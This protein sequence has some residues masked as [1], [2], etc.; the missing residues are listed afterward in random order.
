MCWPSS[1]Q[2]FGCK[3][4]KNVS[5]HQLEWNEH[6]FLLPSSPND[7]NPRIAH[8]PYATFPASLNGLFRGQMV[9]LIQTLSYKSLV[10]PWGEVVG[11][12]VVVSLLYSHEISAT[13]ALETW[14][15]SLQTENK[16]WWQKSGAENLK[17]GELWENNPFPFEMLPFFSGDIRSY[18][19]RV[20]LILAA[21]GCISQL[22][23]IGSLN[24]QEYHMPPENRP[25]FSHMNLSLIPHVYQ[26]SADRNLALWLPVVIGFEVPPAPFIP[27]FQSIRS[28][29]QSHVT[30]H[31]PTLHLLQRLQWVQGEQHRRVVA[32]CKTQRIVASDLLS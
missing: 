24:H 29:I 27:P 10:S 4:R 26:R 8:P 1:K 7:G 3:I 31:G 32:R 5:N 20:A 18:S 17:H 12:G 22:V 15:H 2:T 25:L 21:W 28:L 23:L 11:I 30:P 9:V 13:P 19:G 14:N 16:C 6:L